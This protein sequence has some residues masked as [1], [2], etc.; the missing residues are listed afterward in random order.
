M[1][2]REMSHTLVGLRHFNQVSPFDLCQFLNRGVLG[3]FHFNPSP[4][5]FQSSAGDDVLIARSASK[6][7]INESHG[8]FF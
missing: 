8:V 3:G 6:L 2:D 1:Q 7:V 4:N 5:A